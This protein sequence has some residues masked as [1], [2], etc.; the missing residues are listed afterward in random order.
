MAVW[1][2]DQLNAML[3]TRRAEMNEILHSAEQ[4]IAKSATNYLHLFKKKE[5]SK[6]FSFYCLVLD[7]YFEL[8]KKRVI[9]YNQ[10][11]F[12]VTIHH[13]KDFIIS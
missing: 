2:I 3:Q 10:A 8:T 13:H 11:S 6:A 7:L 12:Y 4:V 9:Q 1:N 5:E